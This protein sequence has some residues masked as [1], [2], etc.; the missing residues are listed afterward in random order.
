MPMVNPY[1]TPSDVAGNA[2]G[3][4]LLRMAIASGFCLLAIALLIPAFYG[5]YFAQS[6]GWPP[7]WLQTGAYLLALAMFAVASFGFASV[8]VGIASQRRALTTRGIFAIVPAAI[9]Y[10]TLFLLCN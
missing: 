2:K 5:I 3:A 9:G 1:E 7:T 6:R 4:S 8:G 10:F